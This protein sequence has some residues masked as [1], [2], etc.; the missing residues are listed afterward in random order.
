MLSREPERGDQATWRTADDGTS[1]CPATAQ[2]SATLAPG[3]RI[4]LYDQDVRTALPRDGL[5]RDSDSDRDRDRDRDRDGIGIGLGIGSGLAPPRDGLRHRAEVDVLLE[6]AQLHRPHHD[7]VGRVELL[8]QVVLQ[9]AARLLGHL[10]GRA[11]A[12][13]GL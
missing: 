7:N 10:A 3:G 12:S 4:V 5:V 1:R 11:A 13:G 2:S 6:V 8:E 9:R